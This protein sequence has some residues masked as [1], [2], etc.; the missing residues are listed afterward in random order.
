MK[1][2]VIGLLILSGT[3][4]ASTVVA[5]QNAPA[6]P[7]ANAMGQ[8]CLQYNRLDRWNVVNARTLRVVD[9]TQAEYRVAMD[10]DC[11][12]SSFVD[13]LFFEHLPK[14]D[15]ECV[16][17]GDRVTLTM[18]GGPVERCLVSSVSHYTDAQLKADLKVDK[19]TP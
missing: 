17:P 8:T 9:K 2:L 11:A 1:K 18:R 5:Q 10:G 6:Q 7:D 4:I 13:K 12:H 16:Q 15:L 3:A 19:P 14:A